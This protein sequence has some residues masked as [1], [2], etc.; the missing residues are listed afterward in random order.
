[1][2]INWPR[3]QKQSGEHKNSTPSGDD[4]DDYETEDV[5]VS[6]EKNHI[7][8]YSEVNR[9][10][11][12]KLVKQL[13]RVDT[14]LTCFSIEHNIVAPPIYLH[15]NSHGGLLTDGFLAADAITGCKNPVYSVVNGHA[16]SAASIMSVVADRRIIYPNS[17]ILIHQLSTMFWGKFSELLDEH[18]NCV[19]MMD[20]VMNIYLTHTKVPKNTL[21]QIL[22]HDLYFDADTC[23]KYKLVDEIGV[24]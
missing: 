16:C 12:L 19:L 17:M 24:V 11:V 10:A 22:T 18:Q 14:E 23:M 6:V 15:I 20:K 21:K 3:V 4:D 9:P 8:F 7:Y 1:M 5:D 2:L 13:K